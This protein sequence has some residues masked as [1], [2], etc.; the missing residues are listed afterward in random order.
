M[1]F[2]L[3]KKDIPKLHDGM[4]VICKIENIDSIRIIEVT[5]EL[6]GTSL[7]TNLNVTG[8]YESKYGA[9]LCEWIRV[10]YRD[11][12]NDLFEEMKKDESFDK[13]FHDHGDVA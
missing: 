13:G 2:E 12:G 6:T 11:C 5:V 7:A 10:W 3:T 9:E 4:F 8:Y 1:I